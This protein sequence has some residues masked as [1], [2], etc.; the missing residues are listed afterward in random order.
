MS[1]KIP[2]KPSAKIPPKPGKDTVYLDAEDD[3]TSIIEKVEAAK[4]KVVALVL[5]KRAV[6]LQSIV[7]MRLLKRSADKASKSIVLITNDTALIPLAGA[8]KLHVAK[9]LQSTPEIPPP[10]TGLA[11]NSDTPAEVP[12]DINAEPDENPTKLDY[13]RSV[14]ELATS[15][16]GDEPEETIDLDDAD[17][18]ADG[19]KPKKAEKQ[20]KV[21]KGSKIKVPNFDR[22]RVLVGLGILAIIL[23][24]VGM[25]FALNVL[26]KAVVTIQTE[27]TP[28]SANLTLTTSDTA[29]TLDEAK[30][31]IPAILKTK[32]QT[33]SQQATATG[34]Q[35]NG[36]KATGTMVFYNCNSDDTLSGTDH[37]IPAGTGV[38]AKG[39]TFITT[40]SVT[41]SPSHFAG[42]NCK[43]DVPS[44]TVGVKSQSGGAKYNIGATSFSVA[45]YSSI[46]GSGSA[47]TGGS[48]N[49]TTVVSQADLDAAKGKISSADTDNFTKAYE[50]ELSDAGNYVLT[51]TLKPADPVVSSSPAVGQPATGV[52]VTIQITY[53]VLVVQKSDLTKAL[54]TALSKQVN[55]KKQKISISN[56]LDGAT[57]G[58]QNQ[59]SATALTLSISQS[60]TAVPILDVPTLQKQVGGQK[61]GDIRA[62]IG[63]LPGVKNV[64][65]KLSPFWV[66]SAPKKP[67]HVHIILQ[68]VKGQSSGG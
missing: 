32:Q 67:A 20:A 56:V 17:E 35:N 1:A 66:S 58:V 18:E 23:L 10:P 15:H 7:N 14:G 9:N 62:T 40:Q 38:T 21:P 60:T 11:K 68:Q 26:P 8:V 51:A 19:D 4:Q 28:V 44:G 46:S 2:V 33:S 43:S 63:G 30:G 42:G 13:H 36:D 31:I 55:P 24:I 37:V 27:S 61:S 29:K 48:D 64:N 39:L 59:S 16:A 12:E 65:V 5:P 57:V 22:F 52:S 50:K 34:Q 53:T 45:G 3:I 47:M 54:T 25:V 49:I 6:T 41:V